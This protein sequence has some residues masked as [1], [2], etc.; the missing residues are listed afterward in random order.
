VTYP[1]EVMPGDNVT[2]NVQGNSNGYGVYLQSL[3]ATI[4]YADA[5]G[6]YPLATENLIASTT[7]NAYNNYVSYGYSGSFNKNFTVNIP[8]NSPRTTLIAIFYETVLPKY[9]GWTSLTYRGY[10]SYP[11]Y[12]FY[13]PYSQPYPY[14]YP[15]YTSNVPPLYYP[16]S[17]NSYPSD[18]AIASLSYINAQTPE[19][20]TLQS[21]NQILQQQLNQTQ[22]QNQQLQSKVSQQNTAINQLSQQL[23]GISG[24]VQTYQMMV[25]TLSVLVV[26]LLV[27]TIN[28]QRSK[29]ETTSHS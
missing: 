9:Q 19:S 28:R 15:S 25:V 16:N 14:Y 4:Y 24:T 8:E 1:S 3:T 6:L 12:P 22:G 11:Y 29:K 2:V 7:P 23:T 17:S 18:Q 10:P 26:I 21:Q 20:V 27:V 5:S 13:S